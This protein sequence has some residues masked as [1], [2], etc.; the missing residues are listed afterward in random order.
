MYFSGKGERDEKRAGCGIIAK[1]GRECGIRS[2]LPDPVN[3]DK[4]NYVL[5]HPPQRNIQIFS[6]SLILAKHQFKREYR[7]Y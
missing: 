3:I 6:F 2:P 4:L 7:L 5:F 1:K